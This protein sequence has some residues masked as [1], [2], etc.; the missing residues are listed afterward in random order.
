MI[1]I[2]LNIATILLLAPIISFII[3]LGRHLKDQNGEIGTLR[4]I[5]FAIKIGW[6]IYLISRIV[7]TF[8]I[9]DGWT[10]DQVAIFLIIGM[11]PITIIHWWAW[12]KIFKLINKQNV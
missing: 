7:G 6:L 9:K 5:I 11:L 4:K 1:F 12:V 2:L 3:F 8:L 10:I